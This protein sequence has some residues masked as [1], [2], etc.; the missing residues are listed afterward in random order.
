MRQPGWH[1]TEESKAKMSIAQKGVVPSIACRNAAL[2]ANTGRPLSEE[3]KAKLADA[4]RGR[5]QDEIK[6]PRICSICG[7]KYQPTGRGQ[8]HCS[9]CR[10][11]LHRQYQAESMVK[12]RVGYKSKSC[13]MCGEEFVPTGRNHRYCPK[14]RAGAYF[15]DTRNW[16]ATHP[17]KTKEI[18]RKHQAKRRILGFVPLN[19]PFDGCEGHHVDKERVIYIP[20][21]LHQG[22]RH[23]V[24]TGKNMDA[25]NARAFSYLLE[26]A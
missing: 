15:Q 19:K 2:Q 5:H 11:I 10:A 24:F 13:L 20:K 12:R 8:K 16:F 23:N 6:V 14:C 22:V 9:E 3:H 21:E 1:H 18:A 25:I 17:D 26:S 7:K 4:L